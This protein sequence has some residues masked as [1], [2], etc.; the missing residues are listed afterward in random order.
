MP[1]KGIRCRVVGRD[2]GAE[3]R[4]GRLLGGAELVVEEAVPGGPVLDTEMEA[5]LVPA[6]LEG[7]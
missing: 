3:H 1:V 2:G 6:D 4:V 5:A 7:A